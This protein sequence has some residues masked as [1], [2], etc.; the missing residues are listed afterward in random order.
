MDVDVNIC[1]E[2][3]KPTLSEFYIL[4][5]RYCD[6]SAGIGGGRIG[7]GAEPERHADLEGAACDQSDGWGEADPLCGIGT[8][9]Q[10]GT[11]VGAGCHH[12][13]PELDG[14]LPSAEQIAAIV[15]EDLDVVGCPC[16]APRISYRKLSY[17]HL[18]CR[19]RELWLNAKLG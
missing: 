15:D 7:E 1:F 3:V 4:D 9:N 17:S 5:G 8:C 18:T 6:A 14:R 13:G 11:G 12:G 16:P 19:L 2:Q 10:A